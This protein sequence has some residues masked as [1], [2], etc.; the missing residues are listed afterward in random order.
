MSNWETTAVRLI[1]VACAESAA[2]YHKEF[3]CLG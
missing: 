3:A 1:N 2:I